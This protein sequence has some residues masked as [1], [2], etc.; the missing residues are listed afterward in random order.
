MNLHLPAT[1]M[2]V[3][4]RSL[5][6]DRDDL[7]ISMGKQSFTRGELADAISQYKQVLEGE[8]LLH[9]KSFALLSRSKLEAL[10]AQYAAQ[11][12]GARMTLL[13]ATSSVADLAYILD[14]AS[15]DALIIDTDGFFD[16][17]VELREKCASLKT[18]FG[19]GERIPEHAVDLVAAAREKRVIELKTADVDIDAVSSIAYTG[20]TTGKPKGV[21]GT[22]RSAVTLP[23][24]QL[25][26]WQWP[27]KPRT[28]VATP[29]SHAGGSMV[30]PT[31]LQGGSVLVLPGFTP[32]ALFDAI[33]EHQISAVMLVPTMMYAM[34]NHEA[35]DPQ[36]LKSLETVFYGAAPIQPSFLEL[37]VKTLGPIFFQFYGQTECGMTIAILDRE[38]HM[39]KERL[40]S[41]GRP[42]AWLDVRILDSANKEVERGEV[43]EI[44]VRG[45][46]VMQGYLDRPEETEEAL[47]GGWLHTGDLARMDEDGFIYIVDRAKDMIVTGGFNV[48]SGEVEQ[49][50]QGEEGV[51]EVCVVGVAHE[52]WGEAVVALIVGEA[53]H[54]ALAA[55]V[56][57]ARGPIHVPKA[58][59]A[60][61]SL[62]RTALGKID[63]QRARQLGEELFAKQN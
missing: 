57:E 26:D 50:L 4:V 17:A 31:L 53:D 19:I 5:R 43:G 10:I 44:A 38:D 3:L 2:H 34:F 58:F 29:L 22:Y 39:Q 1:A 8:G 47:S 46:L 11:M 32:E 9:G 40:T 13:S 37:A 35:F 6:R 18:V 27:S 56:R 54:D 33:E 36:R 20:G 61:E 7:A 28:L 24:I 49:V 59:F 14:N 55:S 45:P 12:T 15:I 63:K 25:S 23:Q 21:I 60:V 16:V 41:C 42:V 30:T 51:Q 62:P 48:Y 52:H